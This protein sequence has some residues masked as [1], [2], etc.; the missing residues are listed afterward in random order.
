MIIYKVEDGK[1]KEHEK[2]GE[3]VVGFTQ[4][5]E[6]AINIGCSGSFER[7]IFLDIGHE[8]FLDRQVAFSLIGEWPFKHVVLY[9]F[10]TEDQILDE[11]E[12]L[13]KNPYNRLKIVYDKDERLP[14]VELGEY[15]MTM[16]EP[17]RTDENEAGL[18]L[19]RYEFTRS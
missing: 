8:K 9:K 7:K 15:V 12:C 3:S 13:D 4:F 1:I 16:A 14:L 2:I 6:R 5:R 17:E 19:R 10:S 18:S 11:F